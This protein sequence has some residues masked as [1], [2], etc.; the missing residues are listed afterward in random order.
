MHEGVII[1]AI[2]FGSILLCVAIGAFADLAKTKAKATAFREQ[3]SEEEHL[4][5][6]ARLEERIAV[7]ERIVTDE[8]VEQKRRFRDL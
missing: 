7:L 1:V 3:R 8:K 5:I 4:E 2:V 6:L